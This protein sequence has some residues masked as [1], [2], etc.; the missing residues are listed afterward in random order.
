M[1]LVDAE[2][3]ILDKAQVTGYDLFQLLA[4]HSVLIFQIL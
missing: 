1:V 2:M 4:G 3:P